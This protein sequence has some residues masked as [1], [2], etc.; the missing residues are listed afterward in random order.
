MKNINELLD[1]TSD[2]H[3]DF[4]YKNLKAIYGKNGVLKQKNKYLVIAGDINENI[5][6]LKRS[7]DDIIENTTYEKIII[8]LGNHDLRLNSEDLNYNI[9]NSIEKYEFL[10]NYFHDY[11]NKI[12]V[13]DKEDFIIPNTKYIITGNMGWYNYTIRNEDRFYLEKYYHANFDKMSF[14]GITY[15][16]RNYIKFNNEIKSNEEFAKYLEN[17]LIQKLEQIKSNYNNYEIIAVS[18]VKPS[19]L[20][21]KDSQYYL[22][23]S[24]DQWEEIIK[25]GMKGLKLYGLDKIYGNAF[26]VNNNLSKIYEKYGVKYSIYG[27]THY[28]GNEEINSIK[29]TTNALGYY[30]LS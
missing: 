4:I 26:F 22:E 24:F 7:L 10:I 2:L 19:R 30:G 5:H 20:L 11:R 27:H 3:T 15:N 17:K 23:Y 25:D 14:G 16:D 29:Y 18:H 21:E 9:T 13:I 6:V 12:H 1:I 28:Q 8:T